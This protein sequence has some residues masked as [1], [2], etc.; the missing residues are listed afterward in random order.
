M[1]KEVTD[2]SFASDVLTSGGAV[3]VDFWAPWCGPCRQMAPALSALAGQ[4]PDL[5]VA[6][7]N[8]DDNPET[9][10]R[11]GVRGVPTLM[12]FRDGKVIGTRVGSM[13]AGTLAQWIE[14]TLG[15]GAD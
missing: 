15:D 5:T 7:V 10:V 14:K 1:E 6:K 12:L 4:R 2:G 11:Y 3:L 8:I 13:P 9:P